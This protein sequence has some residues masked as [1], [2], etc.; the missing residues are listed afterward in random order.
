MGANAFMVMELIGSRKGV[1]GNVLG[2]DGN[3]HNFSI[4]HY[5]SIFP[6]ASF[7]PVQAFGSPFGC[8]FGGVFC[9]LR[10]ASGK[11]QPEA[12]DRS[13]RRINFWNSWGAHDQ[14]PAE[15]NGAG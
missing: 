6:T 3:P 10:G 8:C 12:A 14:P 4:G 15:L 5:C 2:N 7:W 11:S 9:F 1:L 13:C